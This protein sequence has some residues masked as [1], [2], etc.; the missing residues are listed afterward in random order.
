MT[1]TECLLIANSLIGSYIAGAYV[2]PV[3]DDDKSF[4]ARFKLSL[5]VILFVVFG[6]SLLLLGI[7]AVLWALTVRMWYTLMIKSWVELWMGKWDNLPAERVQGF[8]NGWNYYKN[9][10]NI[11]R[12][13]MIEVAKRNGIALP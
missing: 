7:P 2:G 12:R 8:I 6:T 9:S 13:W 4:W 1:L 5:L 10:G 11:A 3:W